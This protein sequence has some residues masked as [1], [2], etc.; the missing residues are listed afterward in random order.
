M[1]AV[2]VPVTLLYGGLNA[3]LITLLGMNVSWLRGARGVGIEAPLPQELIRPVRA[4]GNAIEWVPLG[5]VLLLVLELSGAGSRFTLHLCGGT[6]LLGRALH[7]AGVLG[8]KKLS[9]LGAT[10][11]YLVLL[12]MSVWAIA[13]RFVQYGP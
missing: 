8:K 11:T 1:T 7:A 13:V 2:P 3:L 4:H 5:L 9:M 6:L 10:L 12:A